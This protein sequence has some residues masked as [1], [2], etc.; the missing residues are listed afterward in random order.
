MDRHRFVA[1]LHCARSPSTPRRAH[2]APP[3]VGLDGVGTD[4]A[5]DQLALLEALAHQAG[6]LQV[7]GIDAFAVTSRIDQPWE[8]F[9]VSEISGDVPGSAAFAVTSRH[10]KLW[11]IRLAGLRCHG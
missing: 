1:A 8:A 7:S 2:R 5:L 9:P 4:V 3:G 6:R 10:N 11:R